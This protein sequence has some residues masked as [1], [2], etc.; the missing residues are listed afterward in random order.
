ME[1]HRIQNRIKLGRNIS[2]ELALD[3]SRE[4][5]KVTFKTSKLNMID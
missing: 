3:P 5:Y 2:I 4:Y 1:T